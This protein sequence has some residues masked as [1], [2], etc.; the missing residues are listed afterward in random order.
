[1]AHRLLDGQPWLDHY[2]EGVSRQLS[3]P[4]VT[5]PQLLEDAARRFPRAACLLYADN[6]LNYAQ[7]NQLVNRLAAALAG[8]GVKKGDRIGLLLP[9]LPSFVLAYFAILKLG[10]IVVA[11]NPQY[12]SRE[13]AQRLTDSEL[14][15]SC[16]P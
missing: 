8:L 10:G 11:I 14:S 4:A 13:I 9:N 15:G 2:D 12:T 16:S 1:M 7:T 6:Q 3:Y 5:V